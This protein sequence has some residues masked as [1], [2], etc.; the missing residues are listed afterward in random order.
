MAVK[1]LS[2][3]DLTVEE[4]AKGAEGARRLLRA[5]LSN[6]FLTPEHVAHLNDQMMHLSRWEKGVVQHP[7]DGTPKQLPA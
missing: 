5:Q 3:L 7:D 4:R 1:H 2:Y 6:P